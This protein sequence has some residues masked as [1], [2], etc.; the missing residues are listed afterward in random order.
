[1]YC[2][3]AG[4]CLPELKNKTIKV[5]DFVNGIEKL[6]DDLKIPKLLRDVGINHNDIPKLADDAMKQQRLLVN[7]PRELNLDDAIAIYEDAL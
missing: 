2:E 4:D 6:I 1:M 7:N 5:D 3:I